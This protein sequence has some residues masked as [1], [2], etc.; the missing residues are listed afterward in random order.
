M[1]LPLFFEET[2]VNTA[3]SDGPKILEIIDR[4]DKNLRGLCKFLAVLSVLLI[5]DCV[6]YRLRTDDRFKNFLKH[7]K[8]KCPLEEERGK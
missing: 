2:K 5:V 1:L 3:F 7:N 6:D 8:V 4:I